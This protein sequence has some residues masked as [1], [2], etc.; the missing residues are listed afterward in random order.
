MTATN[1]AFVDTWGPVLVPLLI[2]FL[3]WLLK[4]VIFRR[5]DS[6]DAKIDTVITDASKAKDAAQTTSMAVARIEGFMAGSNGMGKILPAVSPLGQMLPR[7]RDDDGT[8]QE[9]IGG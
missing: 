7:E 5:L 8:T 6:Q 3:A 1:N 9:K 4:A 2:G